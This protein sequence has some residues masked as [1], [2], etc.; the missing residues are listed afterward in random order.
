MSPFLY[1]KQ[2]AEKRAPLLLMHG[3]EDTNPGTHLMQSERFFQALKGH[4]AVA[5]LVVL[6]KERHGYAARESILHS[7]HEQDEWLRVHNAPR[8]DVS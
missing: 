1:A 3:Q 7:L 2:L 8:A 6:P 4:G 5:K